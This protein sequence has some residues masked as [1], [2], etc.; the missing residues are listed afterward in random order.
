LQFFAGV[1]V[2]VIAGAEILEV[3]GTIIAMYGL[4]HPEEDEVLLSELDQTPAEEAVAYQQQEEALINQLE[5]DGVLSKDGQIEEGYCSFTP[6]TKVETKHGEQAIG[7]VKIGE[8]VLAY[9][10]K[11]KKME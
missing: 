4:S 1:A 2:V 10:P 3:G 11:T 7:S 5:T 6:Q 8:K 9:N